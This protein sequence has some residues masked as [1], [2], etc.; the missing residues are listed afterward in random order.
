[1]MNLRTT[2]VALALCLTPVIAFGA[3]A[4][5]AKAPASSAA[6]VKKTSA[7]KGTHHGRRAAKRVEAKKA[8]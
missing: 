1:M 8:Q 7:K 2:V 3:D 5:P 4:A 6:T